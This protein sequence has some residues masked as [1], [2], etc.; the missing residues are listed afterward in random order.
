MG[1]LMFVRIQSQP[2]RKRLRDDVMISTKYLGWIEGILKK[3]DFVTF[4]RFI[5][6]SHLGEVV[7]YGWIDRKQDSYK[8][9]VVLVFFFN[10]KKRDIIPYTSS[11]E[12]SERILKI[13]DPKTKHFDCSRVENV[14]KIPNCI[15]LK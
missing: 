14:F 4:D 6:I 11:K 7:V 13:V 3:M 1:V 15:R 8:D 12:Y 5:D 9:F 10:E 2:S